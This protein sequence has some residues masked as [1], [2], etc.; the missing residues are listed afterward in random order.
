[1]VPVPNRS[2]ILWKRIVHKEFGI[3]SRTKCCWNPLMADVQ[4]CVF[5][6]HCPGVNSE[7]KEHGKLSI[8]FAAEQETIETIFRILVFCKSVQSLRSSGKRVWRMWIPSRSIRAT[9]CGDGTINC[10]QW[11]EVRSSFGERWFSISI[12]S[13]AATW[14]ANWKSFPDRLNWVNKFCNDTGFI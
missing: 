6:P 1:M 3:T 11:N 5:R 8:H 12:F 7:A 10:G 13:I 2:G 4:F 14:R 9:W